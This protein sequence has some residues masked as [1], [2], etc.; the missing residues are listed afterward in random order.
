MPSINPH[1]I[2]TQKR[3]IQLF[4]DLGYQYYGN[5]ETRTNNLNVEEDYLKEFLVSQ[6]YSETVIK[7]TIDEVNLLAHT[8]AGNLYEKNKNF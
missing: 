1:E 2:A 3:V 7:K 5:W 4:I 6:G 8:N